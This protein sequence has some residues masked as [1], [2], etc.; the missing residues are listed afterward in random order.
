MTKSDGGSFF[1]VCG[2]GCLGPNHST[3]HLERSERS[4]AA[5]RPLEYS[6]RQAFRGFLGTRTLLLAIFIYLIQ[7]S[8]R[9][10]SAKVAPKEV[11][12]PSASCEHPAV[13][14]PGSSN[15][16]SEALFPK[17]RTSGRARRAS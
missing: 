10:L 9:L 2:I 3:R 14:A 15:S 11:A 16:R 4:E 12:R 1:C 13:A 17:H 6:L 8:S 7:A 5:A